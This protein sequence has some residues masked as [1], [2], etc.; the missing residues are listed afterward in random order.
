[1]LLSLRENGLASLF[2]EVRVFKVVWS[3]SC[4]QESSDNFLRLFSKSCAPTTRPELKKMMTALSSSQQLLLPSFTGLCNCPSA[5]CVLIEVRVE[6]H[7]PRKGEM[8]TEYYRDPLKSLGTGSTLQIFEMR[9]AYMLLKNKLNSSMRIQTPQHILS[10]FT[11]SAYQYQQSFQENTGPHCIRIN[12]FFVCH[13]AWSSKR[14]PERYSNVLSRQYQ[15]NVAMCTCLAI[16]W[17]FW[18]ELRNM[19]VFNSHRQCCIQTRPLSN[20][21][22]FLKIGDEFQGP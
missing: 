6:E 10:V 11:K 22:L 14:K 9:C 5:P 12:V 16:A 20:V 18:C 21:R 1:M 4:G 2:K 7:R 19:F 8:H 13:E 17:F 3:K 15:H